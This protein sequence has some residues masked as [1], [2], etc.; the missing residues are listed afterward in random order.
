MKYNTRP[1]CMLLIRDDS[2][3]TDTFQT[4]LN[5]LESRHCITAFKNIKLCL[6]HLKKGSNIATPILFFN[7]NNS[8]CNCLNEIMSVRNETKN[9]N[10]SIA[11]YDPKSMLR[12]EDIFV[13]GANIYIKKSNDILELK[14]VLKKVINI[15]W[16]FE[17]GKFNR[18]TFFV[19]V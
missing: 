7:L 9:K 16:H 4:A 1:Q 2:K 8:G 18:E 19:S 14:K 15:D 6:D 10:L 5:N 11:V 12:D 13:A 3:I 17:S